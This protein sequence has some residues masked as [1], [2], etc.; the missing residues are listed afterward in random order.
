[1]PAGAMVS[2]DFS[3]MHFHS[4]PNLRPAEVQPPTTERHTPAVL[5]RKLARM[6]RRRALRKGGTIALYGTMV[7]LIVLWGAY[8]ASWWQA[9]AR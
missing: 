8:V 9:A 2:K 4:D 6:R 1:M 3:N 7:V 5:A